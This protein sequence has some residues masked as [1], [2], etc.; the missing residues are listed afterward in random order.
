METYVSKDGKNINV[1]FDYDVNVKN[2]IKSLGGKW[3]SEYKEWAVP[4]DNKNELD[5]ILF[6][7]YGH[8][9]RN[10]FHSVDIA[11]DVEN[12]IDSSLSIAGIKVM[13]RRGR[14]WFPKFYNDCILLKGK[15]KDSGGSYKNPCLD[16]TKEDGIVVKIKNFPKS[17]IN[18]LCFK[19]IILE[20]HPIES[21]VDDDKLDTNFLINELKSRGYEVTF[22]KNNIEKKDP[23]IELLDD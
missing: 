1:M 12:W 20:D 9:G 19:Y 18:E 11:V 2:A 22:I 6:D 21:E 17:K 3:D 15:L 13:D 10:K 23:E 4:I 8:N 5:N 7:F 16:I 14:D